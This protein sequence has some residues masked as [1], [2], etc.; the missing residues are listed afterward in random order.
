MW[1]RGT[2][3]NLWHFPRKPPST[4]GKSTDCA[5]WITRLWINLWIIFRIS[6]LWELERFNLWEIPHLWEMERFFL[7]N[8]W[9]IPR[10]RHKK[11]RGFRPSFCYAFIIFFAP[12][13]NQLWTCQQLSCNQIATL[14]LLRHSL[15]KSSFPRVLALFM[16]FAV[17]GFK[18]FFLLL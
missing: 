4:A 1:N 15:R 5:L 2:L 9:E 6:D 14:L 18:D 16:R 12:P 8:L 3:F 10:S 11:K 17:R 7:L 13:L